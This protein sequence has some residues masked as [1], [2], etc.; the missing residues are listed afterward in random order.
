MVANKENGNM[1]IQG[2]YLKNRVLLLT[3]GG[4]TCCHYA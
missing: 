1:H 4:A 3:G 2:K